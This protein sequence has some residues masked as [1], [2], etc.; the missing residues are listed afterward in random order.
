MEA[1][2][3]WHAL[4][5]QSSYMPYSSSVGQDMGSTPSLTSIAKRPGLGC[6]EKNDESLAAL[7]L[8][9][10]IAP[11]VIALLVCVTRIIKLWSEV[12]KLQTRV[13]SFWKTVSRPIAEPL[14]QLEDES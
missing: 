5:V 11:S 4:N 14:M 1:F 9:L 2:R 12:P 8:G 6:S 7:H 13:W 3:A 10:S